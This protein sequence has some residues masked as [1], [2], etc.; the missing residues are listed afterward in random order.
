MSKRKLVIILVIILIS[1]FVYFNFNKSKEIVNQP[2]M[3]NV[4]KEMEK[5]KGVVVII[6]D[7]PRN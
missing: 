3:E 4:K 7:E 2:Q 1:L 5:Q 6:D